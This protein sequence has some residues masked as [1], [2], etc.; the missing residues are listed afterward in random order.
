MKINPI[1]SAHKT[2]S[3]KYLNSRHWKPGLITLCV[4]AFSCINSEAQPGL[5]VYLE[6]GKINPSQGIFL[7]SASEGHIN[8]GRNACTI[9]S[10]FDL[11]N[12]GT[13]GFSG[14]SVAAERSI[15]LKP[16]RCE[17]SGLFMETLHSDILRITDYG[18]SLSAH[19]THFDLS[20]GTGFKIYAFRQKYLS[21]YH[22]EGSASKTCENFNLLYSIGYHINNSG[23]KWDAGISITDLD[24]FVINQS[25]NPC[26]SIF[27]HLKI[28][29]LLSLN[30]QAMCKTA[31][32]FNMHGDIFG[33]YLR[34][35]ILWNF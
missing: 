1:S 33:Y 7:R 3:R 32:L 20:I 25:T 9:G 16:F 15:L 11:R 19:L 4:L 13:A 14:I 10:R 23:R 28:S 34:I 35:G 30:I 22:I 18:I 31:G 21:L 5:L 27:A 12:T 24:Y 26:F 29:E 6:S 2:G 8:F 17:L